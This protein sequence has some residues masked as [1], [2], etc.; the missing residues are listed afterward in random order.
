MRKGTIQAGSVAIVVSL[1][2][3]AVA[4]GYL[5]LATHSASPASSA[6]STTQFSSWSVSTSK[7]TSLGAS[8]LNPGP[9]S[10][11]PA[12]WAN[13][14]GRPVQGLEIT[15]DDI[16]LDSTAPG[17]NVSLSQLYSRIVGSSPFRAQTAGYGWVT[18][19]WSSMEMGGNNNPLQWYV[20]G[21]FVRLSGGEPRGF[22]QAFYNLATGN[23][24]TDYEGTLAVSCPPN[25][26]TATGG[27]LD[28]PSP[29]YFPVGQPVG[30]NMSVSD[31]TS[32]D[33]NFSSA[34][35]CLGSF[36]ILQGN[37]TGPEVFDSSKHA[38]CS[39]TPLNLLLGPEQSYNQTFYWNQTNDAGQQVPEGVYE[40]MGLIAGSGQSMP[41]GQIHVGITQ[42][43]LVL[44]ASVFQQKFAFMGYVVNEGYVA[45]GNPVELTW[46]LNNNAGVHYQLETSRCSYTYKILN[47]SNVVVYDSAKALGCNSDQLLDNPVP[48]YD[49]V[50][51]VL[52]WNQKDSPGN[53]V[54]PGVYRVII[55]LHVVNMGHVFNKT[56]ESDF[57]ITPS[58]GPPSGDKIVMGNPSICSATC[59]GPTAGVYAPVDTNGNYTSLKLYLNGTLVGTMG[60]PPPCCKLTYEAVFDVP[61]DNKTSNM[62]YGISYDLIVIGTFQ[63]ESTTAAWTTVRIG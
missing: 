53:P 48:E 25:G 26:Y 52:F 37:T 13:V 46:S 41:W 5:A 22:V 18:I 59:L 44:N 31:H 62:V 16:M 47:F 9:L 39:G 42:S 24:T 51:Q 36:T 45:P 4:V 35:S 20:L 38:G 27:S 17:N 33:Y 28:G 30:I 54:P 3:A 29:G 60:N 40:L 10:T 15:G 7:A 23:V 14:C 49:G 56:S 50:S 57:E 43:T 6:A 32:Y 2:L 19:S 55:D 61:L 8:P 34:N 21:Q 58:G 11:F 1:S 63:D 12:D